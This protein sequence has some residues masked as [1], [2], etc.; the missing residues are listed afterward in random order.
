MGI[1]RAEIKVSVF[2][3]RAD[4]E[5]C[6]LLDIIRA[7]VIVV[8]AGTIMFIPMDLTLQNRGTMVEHR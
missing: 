7:A 5:Y 3:H 4:T 1:L 8:H 6:N 2:V